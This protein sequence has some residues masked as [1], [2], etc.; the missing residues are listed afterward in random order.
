MGKTNS[1]LTLAIHPS[2]SSSPLIQ[3]L[4]EKG[5]QVIVD[6]RLLEVEMG[7]EGVQ[8]ID[9]ILAPNAWR[10]PQETLTEKN[11]DMALKAARAQKVKPKKKGKKGVT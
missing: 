5:H 10:M 1:P 11:L 9:V 6:N 4:K 3:G 2:L 7:V 8:P